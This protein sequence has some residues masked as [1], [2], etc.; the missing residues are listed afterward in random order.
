[1]NIDAVPMN[2]GLERSE[3]HVQTPQ[4]I[5]HELKSAR[6]FSELDM[7]WGYHQLDVDEETKNRSI[8]QTHEGI[9]RM[10]K[11]YFGPSS[12]SGIFHKEVRKALKGLKGVVSIHDNIAVHGENAE[13]HY[14][15]L[16][17]CLERCR[18]KGIVLKPSKSK[19]FMR[20]MKWFGRVVKGYGVTAD[21]D[22]QSRSL[23]MTCQFDA[24]FSFNSTLGISYEDVT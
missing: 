20:R 7:G 1:M 14:E 4:E 15:N 17:K 24:K 6:L 22:K 18:E 12:M 11:G 13:D 21:P 5:R 8:F 23:L 9:H 3:Y 2:H 10:E 16:K 19:F